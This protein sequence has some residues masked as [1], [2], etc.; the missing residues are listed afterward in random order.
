MY[1]FTTAS[2]SHNPELQAKQAQ[3]CLC[4]LDKNQGL[5][6]A[7]LARY[8]TSGSESQIG[9]YSAITAP[10]AYYTD[11][12]KAVKLWAKRNCPCDINPYLFECVTLKAVITEQ[13]R[14]DLVTGFHRVLQSLADVS[15]LTCVFTEGEKEKGHMP[16]VE[17][18]TNAY[19]NLAAQVKC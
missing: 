8:A 2:F 12:V 10:K 7:V 5:T 1:L 6:P 14:K 17:D 15:C 9:F 18:P 19:N 11:L 4:N 13:N 3:K 16:L